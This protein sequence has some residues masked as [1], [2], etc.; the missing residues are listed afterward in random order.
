MANRK[1]RK[2][3]LLDGSGCSSENVGVFFYPN[4][5]C[6][7]PEARRDVLMGGGVLS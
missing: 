4:L 6:D 2:Q 1:C 7:E 3:I 5:T